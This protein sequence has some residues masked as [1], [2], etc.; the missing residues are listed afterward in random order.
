MVKEA[1]IPKTVTEIGQ[2]AFKGTKELESVTIPDSV[3]EIHNKAFSRCSSLRRI[4]IPMNCVVANN[5]F[6]EETEVIRRE[7][8]KAERRL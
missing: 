5:A 4:E 8:Q 2:R 3:T 6:D 7:N 1:R